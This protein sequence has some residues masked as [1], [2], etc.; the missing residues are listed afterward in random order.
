MVIKCGLVIHIKKPWICATPDGIVI[1]DGTP[2]NVLEIKCPISFKDKD[3]IDPI[4]NIPNLSYLK[5]ID[6]KV[7]LKKMS[8]ILHTM[9]DINVHYRVKLMWFFLF[10]TILYQNYYWLKRMKN[11]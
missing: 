10:T 2:Q 1:V 11:V 5:M 4:T 9:P 6:G 8:Y 7:S 3:I